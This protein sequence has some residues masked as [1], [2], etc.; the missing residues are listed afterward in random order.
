MPE[1]LQQSSQDSQAMPG[2]STG[3]YPDVSLH[4]LRSLGQAVTAGTGWMLWG[5]GGL[6][7]Y[8][9]C[10][11]VC[12]TATVRKV[13]AAIGCTLRAIGCTLRRQVPDLATDKARIMG[14]M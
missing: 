11:M 7:V 14:G 9:R 12:S 2:N 10:A 13:V 8:C 4:R 5:Q 6:H 3:V 1:S